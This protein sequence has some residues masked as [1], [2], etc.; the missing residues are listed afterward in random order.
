[1]I[2]SFFLVLH[3][4]IS[5]MTVFANWQDDFDSYRTTMGESTYALLSKQYQVFANGESCSIAAPCIKQISIVENGEPIV[6]VA[7]MQHDR[8]AV[9]SDTELPLAHESIEDIDSRSDQ[10][11][12]MR[13]S[14]FQ[15]L[16]TMIVEL[17]LLAVDFGYEVGSL[18]IKVFEGLRDLGMQK[19]LFDNK[20]AMIMTNNPIMT[21]EQ[22]YAETSKWVSPYIDNVPPHSTG[23]AIDIHLWNNKTHSFCDMGRFNKGGSLA[24]TFSSDSR[25]TEQQQKNRLLFLIASTRAGLT[26]Y[27]FE[28]WHFSLGD[29]YAAYW[30][31]A[32]C[33]QYGS[34]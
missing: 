7:M 14:V 12:C 17:D 34:L 27:S 21:Y 22:A 24:P 20:M 10:H 18:E 25:I 26:N 2:R 3:L 1:M 23:A 16:V 15:A 13:A 31:D 30:R 6:D 33:A 4:L 5:S 28:F 32:V 19:K 8:I 11:G 29:R 9:M